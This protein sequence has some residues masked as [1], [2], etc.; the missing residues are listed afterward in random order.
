MLPLNRWRTGGECKIKLCFPSPPFFFSNFLAYFFHPFPAYPNSASDLGRCPQ[1]TRA[2]LGCL[3]IFGTVSLQ[4]NT[5]DNINLM[6]LI[7]YVK[8]NFIGRRTIAVVKINNSSRKI[9]YRSPI[10]RPQYFINQYR[11]VHAYCKSSYM[12][13]EVMKN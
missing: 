13:I 11:N 10:G 12:S 8:Y 5:S 3:K 4:M 6:N 7:K 2:K 9:W 1:R